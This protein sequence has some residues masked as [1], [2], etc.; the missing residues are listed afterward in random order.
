MSTASGYASTAAPVGAAIVG[1]TWAIAGALGGALPGLLGGGPP[2]AL[3]GA[4]GGAALLGGIGM[5]VGG[6]VYGTGGAALGTMVGWQESQKLEGIK[7]G[8][9]RIQQAFTSHLSVNSKGNLQFRFDVADANLGDTLLITGLD[10]A[11]VRET[12]CISCQNELTI[13]VNFG[14]VRSPLIIKIGN[15]TD[16]TIQLLEEMLSAAEMLP[17]Y[18]IT[19]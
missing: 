13:T 3:V 9:T 5:A 10:F 16:A 1:T 14:S 6:A 11:V 19:E 8:F 2:G 7:D 18:S 17:A 15:L 12:W 4:A